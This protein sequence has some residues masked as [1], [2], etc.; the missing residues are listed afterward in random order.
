MTPSPYYPYPFLQNFRN[1]TLVQHEKRPWGVLMD[2]SIPG[3]RQ[4]SGHADRQ[5]CRRTG[6]GWSP[7]HAEHMRPG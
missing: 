7:L 1:I 3:I 4:I 6:T 2:L 5:D